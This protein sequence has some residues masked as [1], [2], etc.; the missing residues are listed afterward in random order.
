M[1]Q[2]LTV[3]SKGTE[4]GQTLAAD[5]TEARI[6]EQHWRWI[7]V[8]HEETKQTLIVDHIL[9]QQKRSRHGGQH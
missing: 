2:T 8:T 3:D 6:M 7:A 4:N 9:E 1:E 5:S